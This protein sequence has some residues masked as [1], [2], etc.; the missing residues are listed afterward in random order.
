MKTALSFLTILAVV[1][2]TNTSNAQE[3]PEQRVKILSTSTPGVIK[4]HYAIEVN[5]PVDVTFYNED[6]DVLGRDKITGVKTR[7]GISKQYD[8]NRI[9]SEDFWMQIATKKHVLI[10]RVSLSA[11]KKRFDAVLEPTSHQFLVRA[12]N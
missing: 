10:Y 6:N 1:A 5:E 12:D 7:H 9:K 2:F 4:L 8:V 11:D 3:S